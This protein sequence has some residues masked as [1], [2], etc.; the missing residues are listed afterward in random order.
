[1]GWGDQKEELPQKFD[2]PQEGPPHFYL[3]CV[4]EQ[5]EVVPVLIIITN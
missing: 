4:P 3:Q 1:M 5:I 2:I